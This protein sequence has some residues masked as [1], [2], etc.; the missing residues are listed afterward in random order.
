MVRPKKAVN[1]PGDQ[2]AKSKTNINA[3][4]GGDKKQI[5]LAE[6]AKKETTPIKLVKIKEEKVDPRPL[7]KGD[8]FLVIK[9]GR[10]VYYTRSTLDVLLQRNAA[11]VVIPKGSQ[12][13]PPKG[14]KCD[15]CG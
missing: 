11:S 10:D 7:K 1:S 5:E 3:V 15:G 8:S 9:D 12:Y 6:I 4:E 13:T 2:T 14:T